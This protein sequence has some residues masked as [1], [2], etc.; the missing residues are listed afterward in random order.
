MNIRDRRV[1][2]AGLVTLAGLTV[3]LRIAPWAV[4][5]IAAS[6]NRAITLAT[7]LERQR[8]LV[9]SRLSLRD[10]TGEAA[11]ALVQL[12]PQLLAGRTP[13]DAGAALASWV[14]TSSAQHALRVRRV[15]SRPDSASGIIRPVTVVAE[16]EGDVRGVTR[17]VG[18]VEEGS[19]LLTVRALAIT[20]LDPGAAPAAAEVLRLE[21]TI[22]GWFLMREVQ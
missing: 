14:T 13:A 19:P 9:T 8:A 2:V 18:E 10:S 21:V 4:K 15:E 20:A 5:G 11:A 6:R 16:L 3:A 1:M 12:A 22:R 7:S 17:F